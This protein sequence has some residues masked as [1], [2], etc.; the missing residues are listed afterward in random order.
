MTDMILTKSEGS[1]HNCIQ[2][3]N[4]FCKSIEESKAM[5]EPE[6]P[7]PLQIVER[8]QTV[9]KSYSSAFVKASQAGNAG[10]L[11]IIKFTLSLLWLAQ[12]NALDGTIS[13]DD[14]SHF[15]SLENTILKSTSTGLPSTMGT[16]S[17]IQKHIELARVFGIEEEEDDV[18]KCFEVVEVLR[19]FCDHGL[20]RV[21]ADQRKAE[22][23]RAYQRMHGIED[24]VGA[25]SPGRRR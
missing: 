11:A 21:E 4:C 9:Q 24:R 12:T 1:Y 15:A 22:F 8:Y 14:V 5:Q 23:V 17:S 13:F 2:I 19:I 16:F 18:A 25:E 7:L 10:P 20:L 6:R 3:V